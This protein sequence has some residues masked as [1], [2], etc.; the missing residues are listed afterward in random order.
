MSDIDK[1]LLPFLDAS[2]KMEE[3]R[4]LESIL[5]EHA[6]PLA[7]RLLRP[8]LRVFAETN[9]MW[10][11]DLED[12]VSEVVL[13]LLGRL[14]EFKRNPQPGT[15]SD[16]K[17]Y[18]AVTSLNT[19]HSFLR[20]KYPKRWALKNKVRYILTHQKGFALWEGPDLHWL[21]GFACWKE[22]QRQPCSYGKVQDLRR[23]SGSL[24]GAGVFYDETRDTNPAELLAVIM[25]WAGAPVEFDEFITI[26][27]DLWFMREPAAFEKQQ[28]ANRIETVED[29][30]A[31]LEFRVEQHLYLESLWQAIKQLPVNHRRALLLH[32]SDAQ[33]RDLTTLLV[34]IRVSTVQEVMATLEMD[35]ATFGVIW[36]E[37]PM[38]DSDIAEYLGLTRQQVINLRNSARRILRRG[39]RQWR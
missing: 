15:F 14:S 20:K 19:F 26:V 34:R 1:L 11:L 9:P 8:K 31:N 24:A 5:N 2:D 10:M 32:L 17:R 29:P 23:N 30:R 6:R 33:G 37:L 22:Q 27:S 18:A 4:A 16:F 35:A 28:P 3:G 25:E 7:L 12:L 13:H 36:K 39:L 21:A 38:Q